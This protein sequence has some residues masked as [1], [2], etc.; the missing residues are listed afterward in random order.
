MHRWDFVG[1][2]VDENRR[3]SRGSRQRDRR[4][5]GRDAERIAAN[6]ISDV[7]AQKAAFRP[8]TKGA[9]A[10][11]L[12]VLV[13]AKMANATWCVIEFEATRMASANEKTIPMFANVR[14]SPEV[15][16]KE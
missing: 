14:R 4:G 9:I 16:P 13:P 10:D 2:L 1:A 8:R 3:R 6:T 5:R 15:T 11:G 7:E 12:S